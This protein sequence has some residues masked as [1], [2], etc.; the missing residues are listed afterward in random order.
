MFGMMNQY[1]WYTWVGFILLYGLAYFFVHDLIIHQ[2]VF[3]KTKK[4]VFVLA[5]RRAHKMHHKIL[6][7]GGESFGMLIIKKI[8]A[9][10]K[11]SKT[12]YTNAHLD[13]YITS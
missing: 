4:N 5:L 9:A 7:E 12:L 8:Q 3:T 10:L 11:Q 2:K 6:E 1:A 13:K